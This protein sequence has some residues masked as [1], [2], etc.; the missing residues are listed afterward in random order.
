M[1]TYS[2]GTYSCKSCNWVYTSSQTCACPAY[3]QI[4]DSTTNTCTDCRNFPNSVYDSTN[5]VCNCNSGYSWSYDTFPLSCVKSDFVKV[6]TGFYSPKTSA[7]TLCS[8]LSGTALDACNSCT[9]AGGYV[10]IINNNVCLKCS[11]V[12]DATGVA[13]E[14]G[15]LCVSGK[16]FDAIKMACVASSCTAGFTYNPN[17]GACD[18]CDPVKSVKVAGLCVSCVAD[19]KS[20]GYA[21]TSSECAC[22][23]GSTWNDGACGDGSC[24]TSKSI[25]IGTICF[26][27]PTTN[28][29]TGLPTNGNTECGCTNNYRWVATL[30][31][32][33]CQ[34]PS[35]K[36]YVASDTNC[37]FCPTDTN[38][39][40][41]ALAAG[42]GC[43]CKN[44]YAWSTTS[45]LCICDSTV[46]GFKKTNGNCFICSSTVD[47]NFD[48]TV[49]TGTKSTCGCKNGYEFTAIPTGTGEGSCTCSS[50]TSILGSGGKCVKCSSDPKS[51]AGKLDGTTKCACANGWIWST[52][53][54][55]C[56]CDS[57]VSGIPLS[58]GA[59]FICSS[60]ADPNFTGSDGTKC[61]CDNSFSF[62][63]S[64]T[65]G[66]CQ[67]QS[68]KVISNGECTGCT[69]TD[70]SDGTT[71]GKGG[72]TCLKNY[73]WS[74][75][76]SACVCNQL[77]NGFI[78]NGNCFVC[79][80]SDAN[81]LFN[82]IDQTGTE[83]LCSNGFTF[84]TVDNTCK[85]SSPETLLEA[86][87]QCVTCPTEA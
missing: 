20:L 28:K 21:K 35:D 13:V 8:T 51:D 81:P 79:A 19:S 74:A 22:K 6:G 33:S 44:N 80:A 70:F 45:K 85:C 76:S 66:S 52:T 15:C 16:Y 37:F 59:C 30:T 83:C 73:V 10:W 18:L 7:S 39:V 3:Y 23:S 87:N 65:G 41:T 29:G 36:A 11:G 69:V 67:C 60:T 77:V 49:I 68:P 24:D 61:T 46:S 57:T 82:G 42:N 47:P 4:Y 64:Q 34:C 62:V 9:T 53:D 1:L 63:A 75:D 2:S 54:N 43:N 84:S 26:K 31:G 55:K 58:S 17:S 32:G 56:V 14:N 50:A 78:A 48:G 38:T 86:T 40:G 71:D 12:T 27:C 5:R 25:W 72:C